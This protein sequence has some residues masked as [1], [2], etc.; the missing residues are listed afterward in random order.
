MTTCWCPTPASSWPSPRSSRTRASSWTSRSTRKVPGTSS[1]IQLKYVGRV[2]VVSGLKRISKPGLRAL[3]HYRERYAD[4]G[5]QENVV[6]DGV[7]A[8]VAGLTARGETLYLCTSKPAPYAEKIVARFGLRPFLDGVYGADLAGTLDDKATLVAHLVAREGLDPAGMHDD[9]RP[10]ARRP[11][12]ARERRAGHWRAVGLRLARRAQS[13][14]RARRLSRTRS[15]RRSM[16]CAR[17][18]P[19]RPPKGTSPPGAATK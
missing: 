2:P 1:K 19:A 18:V 15:P 16:R 12:S 9:R 8:A 6:Y 7:A 5:W 13:R 10:R 3:T 4:L 17:L 14:R 11:R